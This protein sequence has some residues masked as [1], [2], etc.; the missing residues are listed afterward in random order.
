MNKQTAIQLYK[1]IQTQRNVNNLAEVKRDANVLLMLLR[2]GKNIP[3]V[4]KHNSPLGKAAW[5]KAKIENRIEKW[6]DL[7]G[8]NVEAVAEN[9]INDQQGWLS[10]LF[11]KDPA[12]Q[13]LS[14][15]IHGM[16]LASAGVDF[17][18]LPNRGSGQIT[19]IGGQKIEGPIPTNQ[20]EY[21]I[22]CD[23][24]VRTKNGQEIF[25]TNK[26]TQGRGGLQEAQVK[27]VAHWI[28]EVKRFIDNNPQVKTQFAAIVDGD[29]FTMT[30][31]KHMNDLIAMTIGYE[32]R[33]FVG[34]MHKFIEFIE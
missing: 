11:S 24:R 4:S 17:D 29:T 30:N 7:Y 2:E 28:T 34:Q 32:K 5:L 25:T 20:R 16:M 23:F 18:K 9:L 14:E 15:E 6:G 31:N 27:C 19:F 1:Q 10:S 13:N 3:T 26:I 33:I 8:E 22:N 12:K 21:G